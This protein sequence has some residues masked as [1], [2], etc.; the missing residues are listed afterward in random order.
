MINLHHPTSSLSFSSMNNMEPKVSGLIPFM[1]FLLLSVESHATQPFE[2]IKNLQGCEKGMKVEGLHKLK[3][4]LQ[5][6]G[7]LS[8]YPNYNDSVAPAVTDDFDD[9]LESA[10]KAYQQNYNLYVTGI[11]DAKTVSNMVSPRC[12]VPDIINGI[13]WMRPGSN[14]TGHH[15]DHQNKLIHTV[16]HYSLYPKT[17]KWTSTHH[18][19]YAFLPNTPTECMAPVA[20]AFQR[21]ANAT[22]HLIK[23]RHVRSYEKPD[24]QIG[25]ESGA[26]GDGIS[27]DGPGG[28]L[29]YAFEPT[30]G[31][32]LY[33]AA[34][35]WSVKPTPSAFH[36]ETI[37]LHEIGHLLGLGH[38][39]VKDAIMFPII[40]S[41]SSKDLNGD[42]LAGFNALYGH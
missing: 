8:P 2:F 26:H 4:Y 15:D 17:R 14:K 5:V 9:D 31:R 34:E 42:D 27:F 33:N 19:T 7:Y 1:L 28:I 13:T 40:H 39:S 20:R 23:F 18:L 21:W 37:A 41:G 25:F 11:L 30:E 12:G 10:I 36:Y 32:F 3:N 24:I 16:S 38:S 29:A 35:K 6:F 22:E